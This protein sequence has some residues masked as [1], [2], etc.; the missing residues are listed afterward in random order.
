MTK[1]FKNYMTSELL[2][3]ARIER[4]KEVKNLFILEYERRL[5]L[6]GLTDEQIAGFREVD[7]QAI[8]NGSYILTSNVL[9]STGSL[10]KKYIEEPINVANCTFS[11]LVYFTEYANSKYL[12]K[13]SCNL[14]EEEE[15]FIK[16]HSLYFGMCK[17]A[18]EMRNRMKKIC[19]TDKQ[20]ADF[21]KNEKRV[22]NR[23]KAW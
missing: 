17:A 3:S 6:L 11:E 5:K 20:E 16:K 9:L 23:K 21:V 22:M 18:L 8:A 7:E 1:E 10:I 19:A 14:S 2:A 15:N 13:R 12:F 4:E